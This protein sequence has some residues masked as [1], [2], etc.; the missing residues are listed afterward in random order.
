MSNANVG[1]RSFADEISSFIVNPLGA[2]GS[3][4]ACPEGS[5]IANRIA[6][7]FGPGSALALEIEWR[8]VPLDVTLFEGD[9][10]GPI[11]RTELRLASTAGHLP[12][13]PLRCRR[14]SQFNRAG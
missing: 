10:I 13:A 9:G 8:A 2:N 11:Q 12:A 7:T 1:R 4:N 14:L 6:A 3:V 5:T